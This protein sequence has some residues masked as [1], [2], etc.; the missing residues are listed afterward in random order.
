MKRDDRLFETRGSMTSKHIG[1][2][3]LALL[4]ICI[5]MLA[6]AFAEDEKSSAPVTSG[7]GTPSATSGTDAQAGTSAGAKD[8]HGL[9]FRPQRL[10]AFVA[11]V[12]VGTP[13]AIVRKSII[14]TVSD[15]KELVGESRNPIFLVPAGMLAAP[16]GLFSGGAEGIYA[17]IADSWVNSSENP[18]S[19][20]SFSLGKMK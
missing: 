17:G 19:K 10:A 2:F 1:I 5:N 7:S 11:G 6:P 13:V 12:M 18:F 9:D 16:W 15:T 14:C 4:C 20:E 3:I 8:K